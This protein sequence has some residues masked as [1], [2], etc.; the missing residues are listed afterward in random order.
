[1]SEYINYNISLLLTDCKSQCGVGLLY[2]H[3][4]RN[5]QDQLLRLYYTPD[6]SITTRVSQSLIKYT[7]DLWSY[8]TN[9]FATCLPKLSMFTQTINASR[10]NIFKMQFSSF[11]SYNSNCSKSNWL[12]TIMCARVV[13]IITYWLFDQGKKYGWSLLCM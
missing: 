9:S 1:M 6:Y 10:L 8:V 11:G 3:S 12:I 2:H 4:C 13:H 7:I 5:P